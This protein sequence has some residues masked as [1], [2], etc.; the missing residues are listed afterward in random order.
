MDIV[1]KTNQ[2]SIRISESLLIAVS[3]ATFL[4]LI[5]LVMAQDYQTGSTVM[6]ASV[7]AVISVN[8]SPALTS[9]VLFGSVS[10]NTNNNMAQNDTTRTGNVTDY[11]IGSPS[12]NTGNLNM[13]HY[14]PNMD[15]SGNPD[16][17]GIGNVTNEGNQTSD[18]NN[19][20]MT[21]TT[22]GTVQL[23]T[24]FAKVGGATDA[25]C[26]SVTPGGECWVAYWLDVPNALPSGT[27]NTTYYYC[28][29]LS[30]SETACQ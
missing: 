4:F 9:G 17:I 29:N 16:I 25:P 11:Y 1:F 14:A 8:A 3:V 13:W 18:G 27:Y 20:N 12:T 10:A 23:T 19:I 26:D 15:R 30:T 6:N 21:L 28:G 22:D 2:G 5:V 7:S 24:A